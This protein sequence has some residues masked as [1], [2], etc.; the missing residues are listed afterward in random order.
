MERYPRV[1]VGVLIKHDG[2]VLLGKRKG[3]HGTGEWALPGGHLEFGESIENCAI[4]E[5]M[6]ETGI[7]IKNLKFETFT[8]D[9]FVEDEKHYITLFVSCEYDCGELAL[10]EPEKCEQWR[11]FLWEEIP[12]P[13]FLPVK[14]LK[15]KSYNLFG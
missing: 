4:R 10:K 1:G 2:K 9:V 3:S 5:V 6:E 13:L 11:W 12:E 14:N 7:K 15:E 8:N